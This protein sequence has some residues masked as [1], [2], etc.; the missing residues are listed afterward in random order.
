MCYLVGQKVVWN[1]YRGFREGYSVNIT[2]VVQG[3]LDVK[4]DCLKFT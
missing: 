1:G 4:G 3:Y 2:D